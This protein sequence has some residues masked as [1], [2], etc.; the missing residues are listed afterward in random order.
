MVVSHA[1]KKSRTLNLFLVYIVAWSFFVSSFFIVYIPFNFGGQLLGCS[2]GPMRI[3][4]QDAL[5]KILH[6]AL[7][8]DHRGVLK[9]QRA[10][11]DG[12]LCPGDIYHPNFQHGCSAYFDVSVHSTTQPAYISSSASC[13]GVAAAGEV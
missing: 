7:L 6:N 4:R 11:Y 1:T 2:H 13:A 3:H 10:S 12:G 8:Q 9:E 5:V